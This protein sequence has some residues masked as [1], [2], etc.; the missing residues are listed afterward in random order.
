MK[1]AVQT[2]L[3]AAQRIS[4]TYGEIANNDIVIQQ[5]QALQKHKELADSFYLILDLRNF[6]I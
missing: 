4:A 5:V 6:S 2:Y 1:I 3:Q